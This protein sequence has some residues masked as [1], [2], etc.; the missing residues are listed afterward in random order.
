MMPLN[1]SWHGYN[2]SLIECGHILMDPSLLKSTK[3]EVKN[4][5]KGKVG[6]S[7]EDSHTIIQFLACLKI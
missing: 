2:E 4:M 6:A 7:F 5:N 1:K 3:R